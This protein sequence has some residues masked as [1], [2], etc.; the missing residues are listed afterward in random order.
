[1]LE[2]YGGISWFGLGDRDLGTHLYRTQRLAEGADLATVT[3]EV[4]RAWGLGAHRPA[5]HAA[6][7]CGPW[8][9]WPP[10]TSRD[11]G[12]PA[13]PPARRSGSRSTSCSATTPSPSPGCASPAPR[14]PDRVPACS[15]RVA[16][17]DAVVIAPSNPLVSIA[18]VLAVPGVRDAVVARRDATVAVSPIVAGGAHQG[19][20][21]RG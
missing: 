14:T 7:R 8:S 10:T 1:M 18:P 21:R 3:A 15:T 17:A 9:P 2:R 13:C 5:R 19:T 20:G 12:P 16:D 4:V 11:P 6:T